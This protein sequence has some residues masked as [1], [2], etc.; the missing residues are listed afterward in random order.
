M[1][2]TFAAGAA[3]SETGCPTRVSLANRRVFQLTPQRNNSSRMQHRQRTIDYLDQAIIN[4]RDHS[5][6][7]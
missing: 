1:R 5:H 2:K 4:Y 3:T 7:P 6:L